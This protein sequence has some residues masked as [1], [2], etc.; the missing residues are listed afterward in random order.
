[1][2]PLCS[3]RA[4]SEGPH[5]MWKRVQP[6]CKPSKVLYVPREN[7]L[8]LWETFAPTFLQHDCPASTD[9]PASDRGCTFSLRLPAL[10]PCIRDL[11][12]ELITGLNYLWP[13]RV[14]Q[15]VGWQVRMQRAFLGQCLLWGLW[16]SDV[17]K[18]IAH[19]LPPAVLKENLVLKLFQTIG[20][21]AWHSSISCQI[22]CIC[23]DHRLI[24][25]APRLLIVTIVRKYTAQAQAEEHSSPCMVLVQ[26]LAE[27]NK[28]REKCVGKT[29]E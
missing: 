29:P 16:C 22:Y 13:A 14:Q 18:T 8:C 19:S 10:R 11:P 1:M 20:V 7:H 21:Y 6:D 3:Q 27:W 24:A 28:R 17:K 12:R 5:K 23:L 15:T 2:A 25:L 9:V 4:A 26:S